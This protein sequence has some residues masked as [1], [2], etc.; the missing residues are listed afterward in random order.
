MRDGRGGR[1]KRKRVKGERRERS[2]KKKTGYGKR[3]RGG[4]VM[5]WRG[6]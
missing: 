4:G 1:R 2:T 5:D 3:E 6:R